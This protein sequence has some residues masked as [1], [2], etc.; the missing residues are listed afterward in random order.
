LDD[1][2]KVSM[3]LRT[4]FAQEM[5]KHNILIPWIAICYH[6]DKKELKKTEQAL[7]KVFPV[8]KKA[9]NNGVHEYLDGDVIKP[10]FRKFN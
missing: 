8:I 9:I 3:P 5:I 1:K 6:H 7:N 2:G 10:V 4:L